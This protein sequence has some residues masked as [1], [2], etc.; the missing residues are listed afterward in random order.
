MLCTLSMLRDMPLQDPR[1][2][3]KQKRKMPCHFYPLMT[4]LERQRLLQKCRFSVDTKPL[5]K[6]MMPS[7]TVMGVVSNCRA[8][9]IVCYR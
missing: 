3:A 6:I 9:S 2:P 1:P 5:R 4:H 7:H 8:R